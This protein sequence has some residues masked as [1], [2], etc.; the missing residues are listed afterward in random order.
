M[1]TFPSVVTILFQ[2]GEV[3]TDHLNRTFHV[4]LAADTFNEIVLLLVLAVVLGMVAMRLRQPLIVGFI[5]V[6]ILAGPSVFKWPVAT[7]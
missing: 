2:F 7:G 5:I 1:H 6:G 4:A 3:L